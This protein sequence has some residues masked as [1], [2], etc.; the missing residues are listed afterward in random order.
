MSTPFF[1]V[2]IPTFDRADLMR[3]TLEA[4]LNQSYEDIEIIVSD[5]ASSDH[6][7]QVILE[8]KDPRIVVRRQEQRLCPGAHFACIA[9]QAK[10]TFFVLNQDDDVL[11]RDFLAR[12]YE[13]VRDRPEVVMYAAPR[14]CEDHGR[15]YQAHLMR[16]PEGYFHDFILS[17][18]PRIFEG[19]R[20]A[21]S[22][23]DPACYYIMHPSIA[24]RSSVLEAAGGYCELPDAM[25]DIVTEARVL[26]RGD[27]AYD[28]RPGAVFKVHAGSAWSKTGKGERR[29]VMKNTLGLL[30]GEFETAGLPWKDLLRSE[31]QGYSTRNL[32]NSLGEWARYEAPAPLFE[33]AFHELKAKWKGS[34]FGLARKLASKLGP[35]RL[36]KLWKHL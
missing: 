30:A 11:H 20:I 19:N 1:T 35:V 31:L 24:I 28:P 25:I 27:L 7:R 34:G 6:T 3:R 9:R 13:A 17:D 4:V 16:A 10:G 12:C 21:V 14:W 36:A 2:G 15:G 8:Y 26:M 32:F 29:R 23:L 18:S 22:M 5:N 33:L